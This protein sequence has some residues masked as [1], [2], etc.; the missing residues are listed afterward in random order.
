MAHLAGLAGRAHGQ[1]RLTCTHI[2][3]NLLLT[4]PASGLAGAPMVSN[5][6]IVL[7]PCRPG[8]R[9]TCV[10]CALCCRQL[11]HALLFLSDTNINLADV[12]RHICL[13]YISSDCNSLK[14][15]KGC[16]AMASCN[17][18]LACFCKFLQVKICLTV[19]R[20]STQPQGC[21]WS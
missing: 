15:R 9:F 16:L 18:Q 12:Y 14:L 19:H 5:V 8:H 4:H 6:A 11:L 17:N 7:R 21:R 20:D 10:W 3:A 1:Q 2:G 13:D